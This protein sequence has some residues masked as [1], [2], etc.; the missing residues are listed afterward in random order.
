MKQKTKV[1]ILLQMSQNFDQGIFRGIAAY[2]R[3]SHAWSL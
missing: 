1:S 2:A 3:E